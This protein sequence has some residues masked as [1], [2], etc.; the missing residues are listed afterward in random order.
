MADKI[1]LYGLSG[2]GKSCYIYAMSQA[3]CQ[4]L[5]F[6]DG[7][8]MTVISPETRQMLKLYKAYENMTHG[9]WP[10][11][12]DTSTTYNF[13]VRKALRLMMSIEIMD[14]RGGLLDSIDEG[15]EDEQQEL[16]KS[17]S[18]S[19]ALLFFFGADKVR[20]AMNGKFEA[21]MS[22]LNFN[23]LYDRYLTNSSHGS[24]TPVL[25]ILS[26]AD[27]LSEEEKEKAFE[28]IKKTMRPLFGRGTG[29][30]VGLTAV[31]LGK[32]LT[33]DC[34]VLEGILDIRPMSG[35]LGVPILFSLFNCIAKKIE[36][37]TGTITDLEADRSNTMQQL[38]RE[39]SRNSFTRLLF[40]NES[41]LKRK[42][43]NTNRCLD[44]EKQSLNQMI[45]S[46]E[47][48]KAC[49][50]SGAEIYINGERVN[51]E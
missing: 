35:N 32:N 19:S 30:T 11:G 46:H 3:M 34:G 21:E 36:S 10:Q 29:I 39:M 41:S 50:L 16:F 40:G 9:R 48:I 4:G 26:K 25:I 49:L 31:S 5:E 45:S 12:T 14:Y 20:E 43:S 38:D 23:G 8:I 13:N 42:I 18:D 22:F 15:D 2:A 51:Y 27:M 7:E 37:S 17:F 6:S 44:E 1:S 33:N 28:Y 24:D 47:T